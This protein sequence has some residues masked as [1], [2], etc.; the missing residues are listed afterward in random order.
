MGEAPIQAVERAFEV[1]RLL[2]QLDGSGPTEIAD[3]MGIHKTTAYVYLQSLETCGFVYK[4]DGEYRLS[5]RFLSTGNR[6]RERDRI[7]QAARDE[8]THLAA[9]TGELP[10]LVVE[11]SDRAVILH[12]QRGENSLELGT[13]PGMMLPMHTTAS[14]KCLLAHLPDERIDAVVDGGLEAVTERTV[15]D[16]DD[17]RDRLDGVREEGYAVD[18]DQQVVG[19][20]VIAA[21]ILVDDRPVASLGIG[22][23]S[24]RLQR[25]SYREELLQ[26]LFEAQDRI[27]IKYRYGR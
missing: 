18:F 19:M 3:L 12:Q 24:K 4:Q 26:T 6:L 25:A 17:L 14:G 10:T 13:Y 2:E 15:T 7:Y 1:V 5:Y 22:C 21:P 9:E 11:E 20:G 27:S 16:V 23:P 8:V